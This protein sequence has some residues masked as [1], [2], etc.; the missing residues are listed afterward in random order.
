MQ[1]FT[2][3]KDAYNIQNLVNEALLM[4]KTP[5]A[6]KHIGKNRTLGL[7][8]FYSSLRT[9][10][11]TQKAAQNLGMEVMIMNVGADSWQLEMN[12][13]VIMN[14]DKAEHISEAA[15][16]VG[17]YCDIVGVRSFPG[18][19]DR[20]LDYS[21]QVLNQFL[22]YTGKPLISLESA[23]RHPLQSLTDLITINEYKTVARPK[24][25]LTWAPHVKALPQCCLLYT[26]PS[27]RDRTRSRMQS[28][29]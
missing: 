19:V 21:E 10:L 17:S 16:V 3:V 2:S 12:E 18:L 15:A 22:K 8:F 4:K 5:Y 20:E 1:N 27:P 23:T 25:V 29:A 26:S 6:D 28:S 24:V 9:R 11:S 14:G 7:L 13:G